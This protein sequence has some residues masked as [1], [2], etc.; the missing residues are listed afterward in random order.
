MHIISESVLMLLTQNNINIRSCFSKLQ[1]AKVS[2]FFDTVQLLRFYA[3]R[4][5]AIN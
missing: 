5:C 1:F 4:T 3:V 2:E